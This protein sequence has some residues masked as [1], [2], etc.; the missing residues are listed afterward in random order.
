LAAVD[1]TR[2]D[3][4]QIDNPT[5]GDTFEAIGTAMWLVE[6]IDGVKHSRPLEVVNAYVENGTLHYDVQVVEGI[7]FEPTDN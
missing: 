3:V 1:V 5:T 7:G 4:V 6:D 2:V